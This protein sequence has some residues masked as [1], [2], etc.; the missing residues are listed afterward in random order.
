MTGKHSHSTEAHRPRRVKQT[1]KK[2]ADVTNEV[3]NE[4]MEPAQTESVWLICEYYGL[5]VNEYFRYRKQGL[6]KQDIL[7]IMMQDHS[8]FDVRPSRLKNVME[9]L[10]DTHEPQVLWVGANAS[11]FFIAPLSRYST[12]VLMHDD[13]VGVFD[14]RAER[15]DVE[16]QIRHVLHRRIAQGCGLSE[17]EISEQNA[18]IDASYQASGSQ[19][20]Q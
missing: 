12:E 17:A 2:G 1:P 7:S 9:Q 10:S 6:E 4:E 16:Q 15:Q 20:M 13:C 14:R 11:E 5:N 19:W 18:A 3:I 8:A